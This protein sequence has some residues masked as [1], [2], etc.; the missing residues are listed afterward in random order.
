VPYPI[1][2]EIK[3]HSSSFSSHCSNEISIT[4]ID[5]R[6]SDA[7]LGVWKYFWLN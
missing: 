3:I 2:K 7:A 6:K 5:M 4:S 1:S